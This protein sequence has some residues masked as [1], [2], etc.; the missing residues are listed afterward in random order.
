MVWLQEAYL[1]LV[2]DLR[3][4]EE[5]ED[6]EAVFARKNAKRMRKAEQLLAPT[7]LQPPGKLRPGQQPQHAGKD[8]FPPKSTAQQLLPPDAEQRYRQHM[9]QAVPQQRHQRELSP[10]V[11]PAAGAAAGPHQ[12]SA[13]GFKGVG[14]LDD[15]KRQLREMV[16]MPLMYPD[17]YSNLGI[18]PPRCEKQHGLYLGLPAAG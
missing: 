2:D 8:R 4:G 6:D 13:A 12:P 9:Q 11:Q 14:G 1:T 5:S 7:F 17:L 18:H 15:A 10:R 3:R 16:L